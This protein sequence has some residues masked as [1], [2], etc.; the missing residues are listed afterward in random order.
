[1]CLEMR[2][3]LRDEN[4]TACCPICTSLKSTWCLSTEVCEFRRMG[5]DD[6]GGPRDEL[7]VDSSMITARSKNG[8]ECRY[9][10]GTVQV[11]RAGSFLTVQSGLSDMNIRHQAV[12]PRSLESRVKPQHIVQVK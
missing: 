4:T 7:E 5:S 6:E 10:L 2:K 12:G 3:T 8:L 1:M 11:D 9:T